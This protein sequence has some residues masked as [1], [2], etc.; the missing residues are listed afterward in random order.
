MQKNPAKLILL[1]S[2]LLSAGL[3]AKENNNS[4]SPLKFV[5]LIT[6]TP[7]AGT[8]VG[9][10]ASYLYRVDEDASM[11]QL[12]TGGQYTN[13]DSTNFFIRNNAFLAADKII[14][15][16]GLSLAKTNSEFDEAGGE[17]V[18]YQFK[19][20]LLGQKLLYEVRDN[21]YLGGQAR[22]DDGMYYAGGIGLRYAIQS[23]TG[24]DLRVDIVTTSE[25]EQSL[26]VALNQAF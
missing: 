14:S 6:S 1:L 10:A 5:P 17:N 8:G 9:A 18:R 19:S 12:Q 21:I 25:K 4:E 22:D 7:L 11:S 16:T 26:Y 20:L 15:N 13:T 24:V 23:R 2:L 3:S